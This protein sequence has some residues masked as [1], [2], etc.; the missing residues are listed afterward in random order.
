MH[1]LINHDADCGVERTRRCR[2]SAR[3]WGRKVGCEVESATL[4]RTVLTRMC[5]PS[6]LFKAAPSKG[7][8]DFTPSGSDLASSRVYLVFARGNRGVGDQ[9]FDG[10][11]QYFNTAGSFFGHKC[12]NVPNCVLNCFAASELFSTARLWKLFASD[13]VRRKIIFDRKK[14]DCFG[15]SWDRRRLRVANSGWNR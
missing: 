2:R 15:T 5:V 9:N 12:E 6:L 4:A 7:S 13:E 1:L 3:K 8:G 10:G 11:E 14:F